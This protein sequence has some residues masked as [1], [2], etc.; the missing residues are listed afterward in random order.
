MRRTPRLL[1]SAMAASA[2]PILL[3]GSISLVSPSVASA[4]MSPT[5][6]S[7]SP[8]SGSAGSLVFI[9]G[10]GLMGVTGVDFGTTPASFYFSLFGMVITFA[11]SGPSGKVPVTVTTS[12]GTSSNSTMATFQYPGP[13]TGGGGGGGG[14]NVPT[15]SAVAPNSGPSDGGTSV[16]ITGTNLSGVTGVNFGA[17]AG[18]SVM[19]MSPTS[20]MATSPAG[21][22]TVDVTV[23]T[24]GG[25][26]VA[27]SADSF[28]YTT[29]SGPSYYGPGTPLVSNCATVG[30]DCSIDP[31][32]VPG[33]TANQNIIAVAGADP[34]AGL[35]SFTPQGT[36]VTESYGPIS[37]PAATSSAM[38]QDWNNPMTNLAVPCH[39]CYLT[40]LQANMT[41][42]NGQDATLGSGAW[43]HHVVFLD[44]GHTDATCPSAIWNFLGVNGERF[45]ASG[46]ERTKMILPPGF[47]YYIGASDSWSMIYMLMNMNPQAIN[48][49]ISLTA[50]WVPASAALTPL[51]PVW[52]DV[53]QCGTSEVNLPNSGYNVLNYT[54]NVNVPGQ[55]IGI[56][57]HVHDGGINEYAVD[58]TQ[59]N[60]LLCNSVASYTAAPS[61][62]GMQGMQSMPIGAE[63][64]DS[65]VECGG[66]ILGGP[67]IA[68][69]NS[70]D[71]VSIH[72]VYDNNADAG[73]SDQGVMGIMIAFVIPQ[74]ATKG[75]TGS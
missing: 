41:Y 49:D 2:L 15:V 72:A 21:S 30:P 11:P 18:S 48:V 42:T 56:A 3:F 45:F 69:L 40:S 70:G 63:V 52:L 14:S 17:S 35:G 39:N 44:N 60:L 24:P 23:T 57:G 33:T 20:V 25:T 36:Q 5:V 13:T 16:T 22:G 19:V 4:A 1:V 27:S 65:M 31:K 58:N 9:H 26:S 54:W 75:G 34:T 64:I 43:F 74:G 6:T 51:R 67:P 62:S 59:N 29:P 55:L 37:I 38:G 12:A 8:S 61:M 71:Q 68:T 50:T 73:S 10:S 32:S 53:D 46:D 7:V 28:T 66:G 47:G